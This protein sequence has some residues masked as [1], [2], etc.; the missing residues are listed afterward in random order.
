MKKYYIVVE[1]QRKGPYTKEELVEMDID[2]S[3][4]I[5]CKGMQ[6]WDEVKNIEELIYLFKS[7][8]PPIPEKSRPTYKVEA[9]IK[10]KKEKLIK[11]ETEVLAAKEIK[12]NAKMIYY[13]LLIGVISYPIFFSLNDGFSHMNLANKWEYYW[14]TSFSDDAEEDRLENELIKESRDLGYNGI[15]RSLYFNPSTQRNEYY[16]SY[17]LY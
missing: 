7:M 17:L 2:S 14:N 4:L 8:P 9:E 11:P 13:A 16:Q 5:W 10:K 3:T 1:G 12:N 6:D 15:Q